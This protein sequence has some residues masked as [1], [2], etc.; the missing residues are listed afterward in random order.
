MIKHRDFEGALVEYARRPSRR[1]FFKVASGAIALFFT[2]AGA[3]ALA[4][5]AAAEE[6]TCFWQFPPGDLSTCEKTR[7]KEGHTS[8][9]NGCGPGG[10]KNKA[11]RDHWGKANFTPS[12][13]KHDVCYGTCGSNK[14]DCDLNLAREAMN[15]C[16]DAYPDSPTRRA[17]CETIAVIYGMAVDEFGDDPYREAQEEDCECCRYQNVAYCQPDDSCWYSAT[18]C[19][20]VCPSGLGVTGQNLC[21]PPPEGKCGR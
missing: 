11:V 10:W 18:A 9:T 6:P 4:P 14:L 2:G 7:H 12:C 19:L 1:G 5:S 3:T 15:A 21:G 16:G 13:N 20:Q 8:S 17:A